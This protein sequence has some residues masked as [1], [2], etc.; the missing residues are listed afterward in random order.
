MNTYLKKAINIILMLIGFVCYANAQ[1]RLYVC[2]GYS[3]DT[4]EVN[5]DADI[6]MDGTDSVVIAGTKYGLDKVD[7]ITFSEPQYRKVVIKYANGAATV[8]IPSSMSGVTCTSGNNSHVVINNTNTTEE[9]M[10]SIE[11]E[12]SDGSLEINGSFK[13]TLELNGVSLTNK[14]GPAINLQCGKRIDIILKEGTVNNI[15]DSKNGDHKAA[16]YAK[17]H[18][19]FKGAGTLNVTGYTKHAL[20]AKEYIILKASVGNINIL[21]AENGDGIH[22]GKG[23]ANSDKNYFQMNGGNLTIQNCGSDCI[24][25]DDYGCVLIKGGKITIDV[26]GR[27]VSAILCDSIFTM[28]GGDIDITIGSILSSGIHANYEG[29][30]N[31]GTLKT[32]IKSGANGSRGIRIKKVKKTD[33]TVKDGGNL[34]FNGT[35]VNMSIFANTEVTQNQPCIG[36]KADKKLTITSGNLNID[37][38]ANSNATGFSYESIDHQGGQYSTNK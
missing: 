7:S 5:N 2:N 18:L 26:I 21:G 11:G 1:Q 17:G 9:Y 10:Y 6:K 23:I 13:F 19:E 4:Y 32:L 16:F 12:S 20:A 37:I 25:S 22:C 30:F 36:I 35:D 34:Y 28:T 24:D 31:G 8:T 38:D 3:Y 14:N 29:Y 33:A 27:D 15:I